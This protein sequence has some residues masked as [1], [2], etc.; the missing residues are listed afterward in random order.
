ML[1]QLLAYV[2]PGPGLTM[3]WALIALL[4]TIGACVL[5]LLTWPMRLVIRWARGGAADEQSSG[6]PNGDADGSK[7]PEERK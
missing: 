4:G 6:S 5:Y 3:L 2:G 1:H 7:P